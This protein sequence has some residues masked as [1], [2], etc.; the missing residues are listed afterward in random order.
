MQ[1]KLKLNKVSFL[2]VIAIFSLIPLT[3][4]W[5]WQ[6]TSLLSRAFV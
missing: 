6:L 2:T 5:G 1:G 4:F 3:Y